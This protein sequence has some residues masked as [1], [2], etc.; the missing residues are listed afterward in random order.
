MPVVIGI[1]LILYGLASLFAPEGIWELQER[2]RYKD[3]DR[4]PSD[5]SLVMI[6]LSGVAVIAVTI[7]GMAQSCSSMTM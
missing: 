4:E 6:R 7:L 3:S 5:I 2:M 1:I